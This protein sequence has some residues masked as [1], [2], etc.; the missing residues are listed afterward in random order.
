MYGIIQIHDGF[1]FVVFVSSSPPQIYILDENK[2][3]VLFLSDT[4][5]WCI[6][7]TTTPQISKKHSI[8]K[9]WLLNLNDF[10]VLLYMALLRNF[11]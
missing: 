9:N 4:E 2:W 8:H 7:K 5:N 1:I 11:F 6:Y 3:R 10:T